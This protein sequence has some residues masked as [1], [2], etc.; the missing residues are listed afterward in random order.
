ME[1]VLGKPGE[2]EDPERE[3]GREEGVGAPQAAR[4]ALAVG[5]REGPSWMQVSSPFCGMAR[6]A[7]ASLVSSVSQRKPV[8]PALFSRVGK[9]LL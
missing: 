7:P 2:E 4:R 3:S 9:L 8:P 1:G 6:G 5:Q